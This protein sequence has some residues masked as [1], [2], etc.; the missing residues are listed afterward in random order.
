MIRYSIL[1][2][3][4]L[5]SVGLYGSNINT[6]YA[7]NNALSQSGNSEAEQAIEQAQSSSQ[8]SQCVSGDI[9]ALSCNNLGLQVQRNGDDDNGN[10]PPVP[11]HDVGCPDNTVWDVT[12][13]ESGTVP[14]NTVICLQ[15][16][17]GNHPGATV[18]EP[19][20]E[21]YVTSVNANQPN[22]DPNCN[23]QGQ[24]SAEVTS[25]TPPNPLE[26]GDPLCVK[27]TPVD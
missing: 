25:G 16:G 15:Q 14:D 4:L 17:L 23:G 26:M 13:T 20:K 5:V 19:G 2:A 1:M 3:V 7:Q 22:E 10:E 12:T 9:T 11:P 27:V 18:I 21:P 6:L 8:D 24:Q